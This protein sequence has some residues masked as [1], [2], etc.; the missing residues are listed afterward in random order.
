MPLFAA[1]SMVYGNYSLAHAIGDLARLGYQGI[2]IW[3]GRPHMYGRDLDEEM[4]ALRKLLKET[5]LKVPNFVPAQFRYPTLLCSVNERVRTDSVAYLKSAIE[6]AVQIG[7]PSLSLCP[8]MLPFDQDLAQGWKA[9]AKSCEELGEYASSKKI[10][11]L[12]EPAHRFESNL[13][14]MVAEC[15]AFIKK[16]QSK[17][18]GIL[19]DVGHLHV[20]GEDFL[21]SLKRA[22]DFPLHIHLDDNDG[23]ADQHLIPG[24][25]TIDFGVFFEA[26][27]KVSYRGFVSLELNPGYGMEPSLGC[28]KSLRNISR[29]SMR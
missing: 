24:E 13:I 1:T 9:L 26:L 20:N 3:G 21:E 17:N 4:P 6:N 5:G 11:L 16:L 14:R 15:A 29:L 27:D 7:A 12:I 28:E 2:E 18:F 10:V 8:G 22:S 23:S 19:V 25:G